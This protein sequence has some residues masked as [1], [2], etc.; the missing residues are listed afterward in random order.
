MRRKTN[1]RILFM[2]CLRE[3]LVAWILMLASVAMA[4][5]P[6][7]RDVGLENDLGASATPFVGGQNGTTTPL[8]WRSA[9]TADS[10]A[11]TVGPEGATGQ[12]YG[13]TGGLALTVYQATGDATT[14]VRWDVYDV[15]PSGAGCA[16]YPGSC[17]PFVQGVYKL[18]AGATSTN[19]DAAT[20]GTASSTSLFKIQAEA[21]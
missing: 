5:E 15:F 7:S 2:L 9:D 1:M 4:V 8:Y 14:P 10:N 16:V 3:A 11:F 17:I 21:K 20:G 18:R 19:P 6:W 12:W 13:G